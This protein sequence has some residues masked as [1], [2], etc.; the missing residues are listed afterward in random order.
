MSDLLKDELIR[1][2]EQH[3]HL[4]DDLEKAIDIID[5]EAAIEDEED[6]DV[7]AETLAKRLKDAA[8]SSGIFKS[9][10]R[11]NNGDFVV[12]CESG[13]RRGESKTKAYIIDRE[14]EYYKVEVFSNGVKE[15]DVKG[16]L[17]RGY[18]S[19]SGQELLDLVRIGPAE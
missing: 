17:P 14:L 15:T 9:M 2:G 3:P 13:G 16:E 18:S 8:R 10:R 19:L 7:T 6:K 12:S 11:K 1:V 4:Q 5:R